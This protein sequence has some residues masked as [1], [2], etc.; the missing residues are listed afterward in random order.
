[1]EIVKCVMIML[2]VDQACSVLELHVNLIMIVP[3]V[4]VLEDSV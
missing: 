3:L 1:M 2:I 4:T